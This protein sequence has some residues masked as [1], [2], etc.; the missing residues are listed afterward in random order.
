TIVI[1]LV[2]LPIFAFSWVAVMGLSLYILLFVDG[3][4]SQKRGASILLAVTV[5]MLWTPLL[6]QFFEQP[7]LRVDAA[8][9]A[10]VNGSERLGDLVRFSQ[11]SG[12]VQIAPGCA[13]ITNLSLAF[14][15]WVCVTQWANHPWSFADIVWCL[16]ASFS[17][18][19]VNVFRMSAMAYSPYS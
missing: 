10:W 4:S 19:A 6:I 11:G 18:V 2:V 9:V 1:I 13:S 7:L 3:N 5:P 12:Y 17:A 8:L 15:C 14:L 16:L